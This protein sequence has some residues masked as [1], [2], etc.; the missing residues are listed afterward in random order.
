MGYKLQCGDICTTDPRGNGDGTRIANDEN[1]KSDSDGRCGGWKS[2]A[3]L[4]Q[5]FVSYV[6][7]SR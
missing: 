6:R 3:K 5:A 7:T 1:V 4:K 2:K